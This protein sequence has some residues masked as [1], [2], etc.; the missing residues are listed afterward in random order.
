VK[1][2]TGIYGGTFD[3]IHTGH[4]QLG[5]A[6]LSSD[7][8]DE[9]WYMVSPQNP[10]KVG[11][12]LLDDDARIRLARLAIQE[13]ERLHVSDFE[14][15][16]PRPSYMLHTLQN[17][18]QTFPDREFLL[19]IG[20]DNWQRFPRWYHHEEILSHY[21]IIIFPRPGCTIQEPLAPGVQVAC[22][23]LLDISST[24]IRH[25]IH[26]DSTYSG[27]GLPPAVWEEIR[28]KGYY[29]HDEQD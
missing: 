7:L 21:R 8:L 10:F 6:L 20:A 5:E 12:R 27:Q 28:N 3:P 19:V 9:L 24:E 14:F 18:E 2:R 16:L 13:N 22:T 1:R 25:R 4:V 11:C 29:I 15:H 23:P 17:L 26:S